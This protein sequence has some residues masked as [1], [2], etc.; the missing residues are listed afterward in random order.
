MHE[1]GL[2]SIEVQKTW[3]MVNKKY[4]YRKIRATDKKYQN[5]SFETKIQSALPKRCTLIQ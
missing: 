4:N 3:A 2:G 1:D 5:K